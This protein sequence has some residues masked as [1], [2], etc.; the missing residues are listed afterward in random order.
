MHR[1]LEY[2][3]QR[4]DVAAKRVWFVREADSLDVAAYGGALEVGDVFMEHQAFTGATIVEGQTVVLSDD[5]APYA[6]IWNVLATWNIGANHYTVIDA[7]NLGA[8]T[9][10]A[11]TTSGRGEAWLNNYTLWCELSVWTSPTAAPRI[12]YL[13]SVPDADNGVATVNVAPV[14]TSMVGDGIADYVLPW[15]GTWIQHAHGIT[16]VYYKARFVEV[17]DVPGVVASVNPWVD[18]TE[19]H[20]D[21]DKL[22]AVNAIHPY[23]GDLTTWED[24]DMVEFSPATSAR[25][26]LTNAPRTLTLGIGDN[27]RLFMLAPSS[28]IV[29]H[30]MRVQSID[31]DGSVIAT[32]L[33][34]S[35]TLGVDPVAAFAIACG[36]ADLAQAITVPD[37]YRVTLLDSESDVASETFDITVDRECKEISRPFGWVNKFGGVDLYTFTGREIGS[38]SASRTTIRKDMSGG[39]GFDYAE[40]VHRSTP[41]RQFTVSTAPIKANVRKWLAEDLTEAANILLRLSDTMATT[42]IITSNQHASANSGGIHRP[43]TINYRRGTDNDTQEA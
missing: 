36:P 27:F 17:Y 35:L 10:V 14:I 16:A 23:H 18:G 39:T 1:P 41:S 28:G 33:A 9:P 32:V 8:F 4:N 43:L 21:E 30:T 5:C 25:M 13:P 37:R 7:P 3:I 40:R 31:T 26:F 2:S 34:P 6:G 24:A 38:T 15:S 29:N 20:A 22:V 42:V 12:V 11:P 19:V